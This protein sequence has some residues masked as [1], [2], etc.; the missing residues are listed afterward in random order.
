MFTAFVVALR[1]VANPLANVFQKRLVQGAIHPLVVIGMTHALLTVLV[2]PFLTRVAWQTLAPAFWAN[3]ALCAVLAVAGNVLLVA[4][5]GLS[6]LSLLG[7][8]NAYKTVLSLALATVLLGE[9]PSAF[10]MLGVLL[11]VLGSVL[12]VDRAPGQQRAV[13]VARMFGG[14]GVQLRLAA[15]V[16]SATEAVFLKRAQMYGSPSTT[17]LAWVFLGVL[18]AAFAA[19]LLIRR[20]LGPQLRRLRR[21][22]PSYG[23]LAVTTGAMQLATLLVFRVMP[24]GYAL[25]LFQL[26]AVLSVLL[27]A[28][29]F[30]ERD[31]GRRLAG[32]AVMVVGAALI[33]TLGAPH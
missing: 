30:A 21:E 4:A 5:L 25:A 18:P 16:C 15:L 12:V 33:V 22:W 2:L 14:R 6:D 28:H 7:P 19:V 11:I 24:V 31:I 10:G 3:M 8:I 17:F 23:A 1:I 20:D 29:Y 32:S 9:V 27:G 13:A 26:S